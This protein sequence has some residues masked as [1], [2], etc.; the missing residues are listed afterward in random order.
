[1]DAFAA[2]LGKGATLNRP[3]MKEALRTGLIFGGIEMLTR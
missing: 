2:A 3:G 1:M